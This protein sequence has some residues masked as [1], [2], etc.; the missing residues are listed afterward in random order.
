MPDESVPL[1][2][3]QDLQMEN[4]QALIQKASAVQGIA[5][6]VLA[7]AHRW[8]LSSQK[9]PL[10]VRIEID[11][12]TTHK[13]LWDKY[14]SGVQSSRP[15]QRTLTVARTALKTGQSPETVQQI[16]YHDPQFQFVQQQQGI[17]KA[18]EYAFVMTRSAT[19]REQQAHT[20]QHQSQHKQKQI[21][22]TPVQ[23]RI[24]MAP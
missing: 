11:K 21:G 23:Q 17:E 24:G 20:N 22:R 19:Y 16:L 4:T 7:V 18:Q 2:Q 9:K 6:E 12:G 10:D 8:H 13:A 3:T 1:P 15:V 5:D 14:S